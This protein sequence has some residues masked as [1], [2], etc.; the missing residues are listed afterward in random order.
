MVRFSFL[1]NIIQSREKN[2]TPENEEEKQDFVPS[3]GSDSRSQPLAANH[4]RSNGEES[5]ETVKKMITLN[6][7]SNFQVANI[8]EF[9]NNVRTV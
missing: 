7:D 9:N 8:E 4:C 1:K 3:G 6:Q 5:S 2:K